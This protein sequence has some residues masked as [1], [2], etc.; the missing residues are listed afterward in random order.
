MDAFM[1]ANM[2]AGWCRSFASH[3]LRKYT[4]HSSRSTVPWLTKQVFLL[5]NHLSLII[6]SLIKSY[7]ATVVCVWAGRCGCVCEFVVLAF[8]IAYA[9]APPH[10]NWVIG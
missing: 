9:Q 7:D 4:H 3:K 2:M 10:A 6:Q 5:S 8:N 1:D